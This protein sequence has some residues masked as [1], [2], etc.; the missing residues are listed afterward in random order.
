MQA[1]LHGWEGLTAFEGS[2]P[3]LRKQSISPNLSP[4]GASGSARMQSELH[5]LRGCGFKPRRPHREM[6]P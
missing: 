1:G 2:N 4:F 5:E 6:R 3:S